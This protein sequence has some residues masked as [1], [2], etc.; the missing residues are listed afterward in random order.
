MDELDLLIRRASKAEMPSVAQNRRVRRGLQAAL[1]AGATGSAATSAAA[2]LSATPLVSKLLGT[3][4]LGKLLLSVGAGITLA[5]VPYAAWTATHPEAPRES[6]H[7]PTEARQVRPASSPVRAAP[8]PAAPSSMAE[9]PA[10]ESPPTAA[11]VHPQGTGKK[12]TLQD[13]LRLLGEARAAL[14][15]HLPRR[16]LARL[17]ELERSVPNPALGEEALATRVLA[18]CAAGRVTDAQAQRARFLTQYPTSPL[19]TRVTAA[20][21]TKPATP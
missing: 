15:E 7:A 18:T 1:I 6:R 14:A 3:S 21:A 20:C 10:A 12:P 5:A 11:T 17:D 2:G 8:L 16:A 19:V 13:E 4:L 9:G